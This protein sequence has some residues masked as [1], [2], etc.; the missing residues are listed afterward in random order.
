MREAFEFFM[1]LDE[2]SHASRSVINFSIFA[3]HDFSG[4]PICYLEI[5]SVWPNLSASN[6]TSEM[7]TALVIDVFR[8]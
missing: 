3:Q 5:L 2:S 4:H 8:W 1:D 7:I 6:K